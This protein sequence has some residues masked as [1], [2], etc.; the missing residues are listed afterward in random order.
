M[1]ALPAFGEAAPV[2]QR[3]GGHLRPVVA[4]HE[5]GRGPALADEAVE[6][7]DGLVGVD[8]AVALD[9]QRLAGEL[10]HDVQQLEVVPVSGLIPLEVDRPH[11]IGRLGPQPRPLAPWTHPAADACAACA[12]PAAPPRA[13]PDGCA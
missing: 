6:H 9:R 3:V 4:A 10:V 7:V 11:V 8:P 13:T 12:A 5:P 1:Y 2:P